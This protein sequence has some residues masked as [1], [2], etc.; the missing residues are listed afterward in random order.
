MT[1]THKRH[2]PGLVCGVA[3]ILKQ[4]GSFNFTTL[5]SSTGHHIPQGESGYATGNGKAIQKK[6]KQ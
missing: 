3:C 5:V 2:L 1:C 4:L 6:Y